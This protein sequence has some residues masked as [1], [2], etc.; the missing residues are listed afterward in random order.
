[1]GFDQLSVAKEKSGLGLRNLLS[2][3][4]ILNGVMFIESEPGKGTQYVFEIPI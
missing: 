4:E 1:V 3:T 2:R